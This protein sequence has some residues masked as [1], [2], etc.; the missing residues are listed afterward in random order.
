MT[1][2]DRPHSDR[3]HVDRPDAAAEPPV[4]DDTDFRSA[5]ARLDAAGRLTKVGGPL[6]PIDEVAG[7]LAAL[8]GDRAVLV[9]HV[10]GHSIPVVGNVLASPA[11]CMAAFGLD[12]L[13]IRAVLTRALGT[14]I[15]PVT[16]GG[17]APAQQVVLTGDEI[18]VGAALPV[19][20]HTPGDSGRFI[21]AG[22]VLVTDPETGVPNA[23]YHRL[24]LIGR[25]R[26]GI[27]LDFGRHLRAAFERAQA[28][29]ARLPIAVCLGTDI[30]LMHAA[31]YMGSQMPEQASELAAAGALRG[32]PL[33]LVPCVSQPLAV[34]RG[35]E[36]VLEGYIDPADTVVE[37]PFGEFVGYPSDVG[38][39]PIFQVTA[40][41]RRADA[42][43][44]AIS[45]AGRET[46]MLRKYVL[47]ASALRA[48]R[49]SV[50]I[51]TDVDLTA[52]GLHRFHLVAQIAKRSSRD[53][54]FERNAM[55][56]AFA[57]LKDLD[58]VIVVDDDIDPSDPFEVE[59]ATATRFE[60]SRDLV[61]IPGARGHEYVRVSDGG[62]RTKLGVDATVP[63][64]DRERFR[65]VSFAPVDLGSL[66][67]RDTPGS[68]AAPWLTADVAAS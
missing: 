43:Y 46:V 47:E 66:N 4:L 44:H 58:R 41:T 1:T 26:T 2:S 11:N 60:A 30:S 61:L 40:L 48:I 27:K 51:V 22:V 42:V 31:A 14:P 65:R 38:P 34:P 32:A 55:L 24:Q 9:E 35:T 68:P 15:D 56:A 37:G 21:T 29:G 67:A 62:R 49:Q 19:L 5:L 54:G 33:E 36:I 6:D 10:T 64:A 25:D 20:R 63:F 45:G 59:Y 13:G 16:T 39:A 17:P 23:S 50:P 53:D 8:D 12:R 7:L 52:G 28:S 57:A 3:L 18:D